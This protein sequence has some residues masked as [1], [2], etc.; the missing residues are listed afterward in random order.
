MRKDTFEYWDL[1]YIINAMDIHKIEADF[2][3]LV[4]QPI[5]LTRFF[6]VL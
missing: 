3:D 6:S 1:K 2:S 5:V 4:H